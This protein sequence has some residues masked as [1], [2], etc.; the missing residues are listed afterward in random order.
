MLYRINYERFL[1]HM[2]DH[3]TREE[4]LSF[5][6]AVI[7]SGIT[8]SS[9]V[10]NAKKIPILWPYHDDYIEYVE[11]GNLKVFKKLYLDW[12]KKE[13]CEDMIY[14]LFLNQ[15]L[16]RQNI[17]IV[18][19]EREDFIIDILTEYLENKYSIKCI[20]LND[21]FIHGRVE[22]LHIDYDEIH[23]HAVDLRKKVIKKDI[24]SKSTTPE[25]RLKLLEIMP[26]KDK[27]NKLKELGI[28]MSKRDKK[29]FD[30]ILIEE[31]VEADE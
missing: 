28:E 14:H 24:E 26:T 19:L 16:S 27:M 2:I 18:C 22:T 9:R 13:E 8:I 3:F 17:M 31:W 23:N 11:T 4:L 15:V 12:L 25:G 21:L 1:T 7:S 20:N 30:K 10:L 5:Q 6:Y 29:E